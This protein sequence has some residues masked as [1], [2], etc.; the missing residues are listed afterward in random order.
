MFDPRLV[1][2]HQRE[3]LDLLAQDDSARQGMTLPLW[4]LRSDWLELV[5]DQN[6]RRTLLVDIDLGQ[7]LTPA[8]DLLAATEAALAAGETPQADDLAQRRLGF[9]AAQLRL[10]GRLKRAFALLHWL[11]GLHPGDALTHKRLADA[12]FTA[13]NAKAGWRWLNSAE[14]LMPENALLK[15]SAAMRA[16]ETGDADVALTRLQ[17]A[18]QLW[19]DLELTGKITRRIRKLADPEPDLPKKRA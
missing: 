16:S 10:H 13:G 18:R 6:I 8:R 11:D 7:K 2:D 19:P 4:V 12:C 14:A 17:Q 5:T 9:C 1:A 15:L 3:G